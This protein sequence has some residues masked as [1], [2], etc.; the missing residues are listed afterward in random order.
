MWYHEASQFSEQFL[1]TAEETQ[2]F[3]EPVQI[4]KSRQIEFRQVQSVDHPAP[5][6][7]SK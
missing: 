1:Q 3:A 4:G 2:T 7:V 6:C 5:L